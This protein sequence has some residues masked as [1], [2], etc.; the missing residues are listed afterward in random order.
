MNNLL[1]DIR[2]A[3]R[4]LAKSPVFTVIAILTLALGIGANTSIFSVVY[5]A[6][7]RPLPYSQASRLIT[8][9]E[10]RDAKDTYWDSS[11]PDYQDWTKQSKTFQAI[12]GFS[13]DGFVFRGGGEP[14]LL[15]GAQASTNFF[16]ALGVKPILGR[17]FPANE[18]ISAKAP[19]VALL[20][21]GFWRK[22][23][24]GDP[25]IV[26]RSIQLDNANVTVIGVLPHSF[27]F[28]P[29]GNTQIWVPLHLG[30]DFKDL[31]QRRSL[32]WLRV[33]GRLAPSVT[34]AQARAEMNAIGARLAA[35]YPD[36]NAAIQVNMVPLRERVV[37]QVQHVLLVLFGAVGFVL[38]IACANV[39]NLLMVRAAGRK[40]EFAIRVALG[41]S[42]GRLVSQLLTESLIL[43]IAGGA[44]GFLAAQWGTVVLVAAVPQSVLDNMPFLR[45]TQPNAT[46]LAFLCGATVATGILFGLA[47]A[48]QVSHEKVSDA[49]KEESRTAAGGTRTWVRDALVV[50]EIAF[51]LMLLAGA[52]LAVQSLS[53][54]LRR[55][56]GFDTQN[57]LTFAVNLPDASYPKDPDVLRF[58][59][60]FTSRLR[61]EPGMLSV[62]NTSTIPLTG[63]GNTVRFVIEGQPVQTGHED[64]SDIRDVS[65]DYFSTMKIPLITGRYFKDEADS[66]KA[67]K[68]AIVNEA[69]VKAYLHGEDPIGKRFKFTLSATQPYREIVGVVANIADA[70]L[71]SK[72]EP[73]LFLPFNQDDNSYINYVVRGAGNPAIALNEVRDALTKTDPQ[74]FLVRPLTME[75]IIQQSPSVFLR[76]YPSYLIGGF[77][78]LALLLA[79]IGL[80]GLISYSVSQRTREMGI[81]I[82][83]GAQESDVLRLVMGQ[84]AKLTLIGV[85]IGVV[86]A[87]GLTQLM[88]S[89]LY[90]VKATDPLTF[91]SVAIALAIVALA[92][93]YIPARRATRVDPL[94]AL[95]YE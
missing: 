14:Q 62:G 71:D 56:P 54:L 8:L 90:G 18:D 94:E 93:C 2:Y 51:S 50:V 39:A 75:Q 41:A 40:R 88:G 82:A 27:E 89:I 12:A 55:N 83:L 16:S 79:S 64:E 59:A 20:T 4:M 32:R 70:Q 72:D 60:T 61:G 37:G 43:A 10:I 45:D 78:A 77:A 47:P 86:A 87:L 66:V 1:Q 26:G 57:L 19:R 7:L 58:D 95:R 73:A 53:A 21:Y 63:G 84:G 33:I 17:D 23:F 13:N 48:L 29:T 35:A 91:A 42:R 80:Y 11:Y 38:L 76:R 74:L 85:V 69:W 92:A 3:L 15:F 34:W 68:H 31:A 52:G 9:S 30:G 44:L 36:A 24:G 81:R 5:A 22:Q 65:S 28:A 67:P 25:N 46:I 6:L 49:L